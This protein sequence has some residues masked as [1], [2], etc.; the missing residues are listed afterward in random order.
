MLVRSNPPGNKEAAT[1]ASGS[2]VFR[3]VTRPWLLLFAEQESR[4]SPMA[5]HRLSFPGS[6]LC[7]VS[8]KPSA[9]LSGQLNGSF[10]I[11]GTER[12]V[13]RIVCV[14]GGRK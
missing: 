1:G 4:V 5:R 6:Q 10:I 13:E 8:S 2:R 12:H 3:L 7:D 9:F 11:H 14:G